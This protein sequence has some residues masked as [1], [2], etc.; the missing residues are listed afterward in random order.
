MTERDRNSTASADVIQ[1]SERRARKAQIS[2]SSPPAREL[3]SFGLR[4]NQVASDG[5]R[6]CYFPDP[7]A[8]KRFLA[9]LKRD[10]A[11]L[12]PPTP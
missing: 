7:E 9:A 12:K 1:L 11:R 5:R 4:I 10:F 6:Y 8:N 3:P 2:A